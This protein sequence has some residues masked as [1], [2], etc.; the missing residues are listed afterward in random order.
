M[1]DNSKKKHV[2]LDDIIPELGTGDIVLMSGVTQGG[3][4]IRL[5][6]HAEFSHVAMIVKDPYMDR[7]CLWEAAG[8]SGSKFIEDCVALFILIQINVRG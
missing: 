7:A 8:N 2:L 6:D 3:A 5:F 1:K 4:I